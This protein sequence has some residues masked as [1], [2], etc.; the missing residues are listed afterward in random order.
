MVSDSILT[1]T[2]AAVVFDCDGTL[3]DT[4]RHW[5]T[6]RDRT[7]KEFGVR[8]GPGFEARSKGVHYTECGHLIAQEAGRP[9]LGDQLAARLLRHFRAL[10]LEAPRTMPG[11]AELVG[12]AAKFAPLAVASNCPLEVVEECL[13]SADLRHY[14]QHIVVPDEDI[15]PKPHPDVY[16]VAAHR[17][18]AA[19]AETLAVEDSRCG[20]EAAVRAGLRVLGVG[21]WPGE[22]TGAMV[23]LWVTSLG[24]PRIIEW[25][26]KHLAPPNTPPRTPPRPRP[27]DEE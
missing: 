21:P 12:A 6:A 26:G 10:A 23:D 5:Q 1:W 18:G 17:L 24:E 25:V 13:G 3:I 20:V 2:P 7:M 27:R 14:F 22:E 16:L 11:A 19:P 8:A 9:S 4:E 15:R